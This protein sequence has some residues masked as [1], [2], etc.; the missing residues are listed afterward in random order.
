MF[1]SI[2]IILREFFSICLLRRKPQDL[3][4]SRLLLNVSLASYTVVNIVLALDRIEAVKAVQA[5]VLESV[6]VTLITLVILGSSHYIKRWVQTLTA[7][8][9]TG[10]IMSLLA[11]PVIYGSAHAG[12]DA[13]VRTVLLL[14]YLG[15]LIWNVVVMAH[16][17]RHALDT[18]FGFGVIFAMVYIVLTSIIINLVV[19]EMGVA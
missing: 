19:P 7:L 11:L 18:S 12:A 5:G 9:G 4:A 10:C 3:P 1:T 6:L 8:A 2:K 14:S 17:M 15:L 16:I 13:L